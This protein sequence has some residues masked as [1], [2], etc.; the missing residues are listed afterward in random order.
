MNENIKYQILNADAI[1]FDLVQ[2]FHFK[3]GLETEALQHFSSIAAV[4]EYI[5]FN[6]KYMNPQFFKLNYNLYIDLHP[7]A[8]PRLET[9]RYCKDE[10]ITYGSKILFCSKR[11][12]KLNNNDY[13]IEY[14][15]KYRRRKK[16]ERDN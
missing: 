10:F 16:I 8:M 9:C 6:K 7:Q 2:Y 4:E 12:A 14:N 5:Q 15:K 11:C 1:Y 3:K 13:S